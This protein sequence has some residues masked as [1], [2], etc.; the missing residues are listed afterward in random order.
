MKYCKHCNTVAEDPSNYCAACGGSD[1]SETP[2]DAAEAE[3]SA[4]IPDY[5]DQTPYNPD[6]ST[7][8]KPKKSVG[9]II[10]GVAIMIATAVLIITS[11]MINTITPYSKGE[12]VNGVYTNEWAN[13][14]FELGDTWKELVLE[15]YVYSAEDGVECG[16][17]AESEDAY[18]TVVF[19]EGWSDEEPEEYFEKLDTDAYEGDAND[20]YTVR[21]DGDFFETKIAGETFVVRKY[22]AEWL[23][24]GYAYYH[25]RYECVRIEGD[26][27]IHISVVAAEGDETFYNTIK[28]FK[29]I[30]E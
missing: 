5:S 19:C 21:V 7:F 9:M 28:N 13:I 2:I 4:E 15:K 20:T 12:T 26:Y 18:V 3:S 17:V 8:E 25:N 11:V 24:D 6:P 22:Y 14:E 30:E 16:I 27:A 29:A 23:E 1:F 10:A